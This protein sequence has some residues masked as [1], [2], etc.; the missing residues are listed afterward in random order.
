[1]SEDLRIVTWNIHKGIGRDRRY[2]LARTVEILRDVDAD[3]VCLQEVDENVSRS[4]FDR[5]ARLL[6]DVL[7]YPHVALG[8]NVAVRGGHYGNCTLSRRPLALASNVDLSVPWKKRRGALVTRVSGRVGRDW[9]VANVHLGLLHLERR[10]QVRALLDHLVA[11]ASEA[12]AVVI[13]GDWNDWGNR[14]HRQVAAE[15]GFHIARLPTHGAAGLKTF[16]SGRPLAAL[17]KILYRPPVTVRH[18]TRLEDDRARLA[19]D[20]LPLVADL[21]VPRRAGFPQATPHAPPEAY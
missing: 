11:E 9:I 17:D 13:A 4:G 1:M 19:S 16:P 20:H 3:V 6:S 14:L 10:R 8:L 12:D 5:Q 2:A 15:E 7:G 21:R 18:V